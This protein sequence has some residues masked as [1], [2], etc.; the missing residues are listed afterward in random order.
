MQQTNRLVHGV[1]INDVIGPTQKFITVYDPVTGKNKPKQVWR[2]PFYNRWKAVLE[3]AN[4]KKLKIKHPTYSDVSVCEDWLRFS[5]FKA[6]METQDWEGKQLDKDLLVVGNKHYSPETC[7]FISRLTNSFVVERDSCRGA[8]PIGV[9]L[10]KKT[11]KYEAQCNDPFTGKRGYIGL[12][13]TPEQAHEAWRKV[14]QNLAE[15]LAS[16]Q[17]DNRVAQALISR[18]CIKEDDL[19]TKADELNELQEIQETYS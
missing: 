2:C 15:K 18:Y 6:W 17:T 16:M 1:G 19:K 9:T 13:E 4:C 11:G 5:K 7:C 14:K 12:Y 8:L 3:R 10:H